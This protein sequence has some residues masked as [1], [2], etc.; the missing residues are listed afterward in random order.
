[1][2]PEQQAKGALA[3]PAKRLD[4]PHRNSRDLENWLMDAIADMMSFDADS[5]PLYVEHIFPRGMSPGGIAEFHEWITGTGLL[6]AMRNNGMQLNALATGRP[7][8]LNEGVL[9]ERYRWLYEIPV[10]ISFVPKGTTVYEKNL[11]VNSQE[12]L[13][14][15]QIGRVQDS[16]LEHNVMIETWSV[17]A[18]PKD[19]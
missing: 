7:V 2:T 13:V 17:R 11:A 19:R 5:Y 14:T 9:S 1:M 3:L 16:M 15:L 8:L 6:D 4:E 10:L 18:A 12:I